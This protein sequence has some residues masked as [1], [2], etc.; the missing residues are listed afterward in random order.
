MQIDKSGGDTFIKVFLPIG[1]T[2]LDS[3]TT[4]FTSSI[5]YTSDSIDELDWKYSYLISN[6]EG[7]LG[8][9][10][11]LHLSFDINKSDFWKEDIYISHAGQYHLIRHGHND[12]TFKYNPTEDAYF[13]PKNCRYRARSI[14]IGRLL[15][16]N[17]TNHRI[18]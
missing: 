5:Y 9:D 11:L 8:A 6:T 18:Q 4:D 2:N 17:K 15:Y 10:G 3:D 7:F 1:E 14:N 13:G 12:V 16:F